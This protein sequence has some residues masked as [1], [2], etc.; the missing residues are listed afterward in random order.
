MNAPEQTD[1]GRRRE[2]FLAFAAAACLVALVGDRLLLGPLTRAYEDR[3]S[4][5]RALEIRV[6]RGRTLLAQEERWRGQRSEMATRMLPADASEAENVLLRGID[7]WAATSG[8]R[9]TALQPRWQADGDGPDLLELRVAATG[10]MNSVVR[11]LFELET[12]PMALAVEDL[13]LTTR[14]KDGDTLTLNVRVTGLCAS[15]RVGG[16]AEQG[17]A[18]E[19]E[20]GSG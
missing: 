11:F 1:R 10:T 3:S 15:K 7:K 8:L 18:E 9:V 2:A 20:E 16:L 17:A 14:Q 13:D 5:I 12:A 19:E 4:R 6:R